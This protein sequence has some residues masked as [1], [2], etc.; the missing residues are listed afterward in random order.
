[1]SRDVNGSP[2]TG[3]APNSR[4]HVH[5]GPAGGAMC[6]AEPT[7]PTCAPVAGVVTV[8]AI[9]VTG[10]AGRHS[11]TC[12]QH[13]SIHVD[14]ILCNLGNAPEKQATLRAAA[15]VTSIM[16][17]R[18]MKQ[19]E[20]DSSGTHCSTSG[21]AGRSGH[22]DNRSPQHG[23]APDRRCPPSN[24]QSACTAPG[25]RRTIVNSCAHRTDS[26]LLHD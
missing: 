25:T 14:L 3:Q 1:M 8:R 26:H 16:H 18:N 6:L 22:Q 19:I 23:S 2:S 5:A 11:F 13:T 17:E 20:E 21:R 24:S 7:R 4:S 15:V 10:S 12:R 9:S